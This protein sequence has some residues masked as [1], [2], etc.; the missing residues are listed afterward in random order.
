[1]LVFFLIAAITTLSPQSSQ[2]IVTVSQE[3]IE[4]SDGRTVSLRIGLMN[5]SPAAV[6]AYEITVETLLSSG[7]TESQNIGHD[8]YQA[9]A[10]NRPSRSVI[11]AGGSIVEIAPLRRSVGQVVSA[12]SIVNWAI[13]A[14]GSWYGDP[15]GVAE[16]ARRRADEAAALAFIVT[17]LRAGE[18]SGRGVVALRA[19]L[20]RL[21]DSSQPDFE[22]PTKKIMRA[23][24]QRAIDATAAGQPAP[25]RLG[26][27][28]TDSEQALAHAN[29]HRQLRSQ[30]AGK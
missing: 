18:T 10:A 25:G 11:P 5:D 1:M 4:S 9:Y 2:H 16:A 17:S 26:D 14:D 6:T 7:A 23:N 21:D 19:A 27:W 3:S 20:K 24:L 15:A 30:Q 28:I 13:F 12:R 22:N 29:R 8:G